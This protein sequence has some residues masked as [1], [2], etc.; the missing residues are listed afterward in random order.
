MP[1][2]Q[3]CILTASLFALTACGNPAATEIK[4]TQPIAVINIDQIN[5]QHSLRFSGVVESQNRASLAFRVPGT[6][7]QIMF[8]QGEHVKAGQVIAQLDPHDFQVRVNELKARLIEAKA[9]LQQAEN[10]LK[11]TQAANKDKAIADVNVERA[12]TGVAR[13][14]AGVEVVSLNLQQAEDSLRYT[15]LTAPFDGVI[16]K[17]NFDN[18][19]QVTPGIGF[20]TIHQPQS[21]Q[22]V[23]DISESLLSEVYRGQQ[24]IISS[25]DTEQTL[26]G[27]ISEI[28]TIADPIKRTYSA[29]IKIE[30]GGELYYPGKV[31]NARI[32]PTEQSAA[33]YCVPSSAIFTVD[34]QTH[35]SKVESAT[36][37]MMPVELIRA[38][39]DTS[40]IQGSFTGNESIIIAGAAFLD[41]GADASNIVDLGMTK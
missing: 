8:N 29:T 23:I 37:K 22:A 4:P 40:C 30:Q 5:Q 31:I 28:T 2:K 33:T 24:A 18:F 10:E 36:V 32:N 12:K 3:T 14:Q 11:R 7:Q 39:L 34:Q 13:A 17:R 38:G 25:A 27:Q 41:D 9:S 16:G 6:L 19:E 1:T 35:V 26:V 20:V 21:I 15:Q